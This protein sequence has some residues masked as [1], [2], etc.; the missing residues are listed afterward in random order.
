M[1]NLNTRLIVIA[2]VIALAAWIDF[3][4]EL[5]VYNPFDDTVLFRRDVSPRLGLDL[6]GGLQVLLEADLPAET[7]ITSDQMETARLILENR[8]NALGVS[9]S[10]MQVAGL[11]RIVGEFP[12]VTNPDDVM[13]TLGQTGLLE[14]VDF[15]YEPMPEG[16]RVQTD[17]GLDP[18]SQP[19]STPEPAATETPA[20]D[21]PVVYH[22]VMT[23]TEL[24]DVAVGTGNLNEAVVNFVLSNEGKDIFAEYTTTHV[25]QYLGIVLDKVV[26]SAPSVNE[27]ITEGSGTISGNFTL[28]SAN[29]L[30]IQLRYG[31]LP[32]PF[33][34]VESRVVGPTLGQDSLQKSLVAGLVGII[35]VFLFMGI[36]YRLPGVLADLSIIV[37]ALVTFAIFKNFHFTLTLAGVAGFLLSTGA[38]LDANILIFERMKEELRAGRNLRTAVDLGFNR[39]WSSIRDS[40][41]ATIITSLIL[42]WFGSTF[43]AT[44]VKGFALTLALGVIISLFTALFVTRS[45]LQVVINAIKPGTENPK[46]FGI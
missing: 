9:E 6:R 14:F 39:A 5:I 25:G 28:E 41:L 26:I 42:F 1:R 22:T 12:G 44:I 7:E 31:S 21:A 3:S 17:F 27:P 13:A 15:G 32:I 8:T 38:A 33:K 2:I 18:V 40:N 23:G 19:T 16:T 11:R 36:F 30:V 4:Q 37:Y 29:S 24:T 34:L 20:E 46:W 35:V 45:L 43:G 10:V